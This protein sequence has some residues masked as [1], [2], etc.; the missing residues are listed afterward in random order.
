MKLKNEKKALQMFCNEECF[1][2]DF[3]SPS[4]NDKD[5]GRLLATDGYVM[6]LVDPKLIRCK[7][8]HIM[9][10][11]PDFDYERKDFT[12]IFEFDKFDQAYN[13]LDLIP[14]KV[15]SDGKSTDCP[16]CN[17][18]GSVEY[19]YTDKEGEMHYQ[20]CECPICH[21]TGERGDY[22]LVETGR[23][24]LP[25][26][27]TFGLG[28]VIIGASNLQRVVTA[29]RL[30][31]FERMTWLSK[32]H[33]GNIFKVCDGFTVVIMSSL[34]QGEHHQRIEIKED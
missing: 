9:Q 6:A 25:K 5:F 27:S 11:I 28:D 15:T 2:V 17:G 26:N 34:Q 24:L 3:H 10:K 1:R 16:E 19:E 30:M 13:K 14:E 31:G 4:I 20:D 7:Y 8:K 29:L 33:G 12:K 23:M 32:Q 18:Y 21:G 22:E